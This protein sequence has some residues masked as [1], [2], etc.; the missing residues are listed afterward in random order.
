MTTLIPLIDWRD[1]GDEMKAFVDGEPVTWA[2]MP[3][4][5]TAFMFCPV[6]ETLYTG[7]RGPGKTDALLMD[8]AQHTG[9][10]FGADWRGILFRQTFPELADVIAKSKK[11]FSQ[12]FPQAKYNEAKAT[13]TFPGGEALMFRFFEKES[14]YW[15]YHG[16]S[17]PWIGW[18]EL[19]TWAEPKH[20]LRM[21]SCSRST[22]KDMPRKYRATTNPYGVGHNWVKQRWRLPVPD[23]AIVG[24][25]IKD[26][27][28]QD[29]KLEPHRVAIHGTIQENIVLL[30]ADPD[31]IDRIR[32]S[33]SNAAELAA[34][35]EGRWDIVAGGMFDDL[36]SPGVHVVPNVPLHLIPS[37][38]KIDRSYD[39]GQSKPFS[40][41]WWAESNGEPWIVD[42][43]SLGNVRGDLI[44]VAEWYGWS[45]SPNEGVR[46]LAE[47]IA[48][49]IL[50]REA[51]WGIA[52]R[53]LLGGCIADASIFDRYEGEKSVAGDMEEAG[54]SWNPSDKGPGS[55]KQGWE[56]MRAYLDA[57]FP[58]V[59]GIRERPGLFVCERCYNGLIRT[60][61]GLPRSEKDLDDVDT[62]A[63]DHAADE[64][65]YRIRAKIR[66]MKQKRWK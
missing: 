56:R 12:I 34:W 64:A 65:R 46:M 61:T 8:F 42:G 24:P 2:P 28:G 43:R 62:D 53:V 15:R 54:V 40:V 63:E 13:W 55:R 44:R 10:G 4:S 45:G 33:A 59:G 51:D 66:E 26:S 57:A 38:W 27:I 9:Q 58:G 30:H 25:I 48:Q 1:T 21:M 36:W 37:G 32:A 31:Y 41:G 19:T 3:G 22:R 6:Y 16:H 17:Y 14:D 7:T 18:E 29:G 35:L 5:Q 52:G 39:H 20:Y 47:D 60:I 49:G 23:G 11:W 50:E